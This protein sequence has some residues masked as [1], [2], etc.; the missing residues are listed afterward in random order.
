MKKKIEILG[1]SILKVIQAVHTVHIFL[2][3]GCF[4]SVIGSLTEHIDFVL[5]S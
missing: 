1:L 5:D 4:G 2:Y 3:I